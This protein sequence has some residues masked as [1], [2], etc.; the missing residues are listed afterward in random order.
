MWD[1]ALNLLSGTLTGS[2]AAG[3][4]KFLGKNRTYRFWGRCGGDVTPAGATLEIRIEESANGTTGWTLIAGPMVITEQVGYVGGTTPR[5]EVPSGVAVLPW[6]IVTTS[7]DYVRAV[8]TLV[9]TTPTFPT[10]S[11]NTEPLDA[12]VLASGR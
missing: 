11:V 8:P 4:A 10:V 1:G 7:K 5:P 9:G 3:A 2:P 6:L 12:P